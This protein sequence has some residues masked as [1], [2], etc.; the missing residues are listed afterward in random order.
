MLNA[1]SQSVGWKFIMAFGSV[2]DRVLPDGSRRRKLYDSL[3]LR[4]KSRLIRRQAMPESDGQVHNLTQDVEARDSQFA[5]MTTSQSWGMTAR[6]LA[7]KRRMQALG[8]WSRK[9]PSLAKKFWFICRHDG[10]GMAIVRTKATIRNIWKMVH[11][12]EIAHSSLHPS[13][14]SY[15]DVD[16]YTN[17]EMLKP[18]DIVVIDNTYE[19]AERS[20]KFSLIVTVLNE[21]AGIQSFLESIARQSWVPDE[22]VVVDGGSVDRTAEQ[23]ELLSQNYQLNLTLHRS[24]G[25]TIA[26]GRNMAIFHA[27][28]ELVVVTDVG[29]TLEPDFCRSLVGS[30]SDFPEASLVG[31]IYCAAQGAKA[32]DHFIPEWNT[33]DWPQFLP[34]SRSLLIRKS[35]WGGR[36]RLSRIPIQDWRR[37]LVRYL[38]P[39]AFA[40]VG[41]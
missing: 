12:K 19:Q 21:E 36:W 16:P 22:I 24:P 6:I 30:L 20:E 17:V 33:N 28:H 38:V 27:L 3:L 2:K 37:H 18:I 26:A 14:D 9:L 41:V 39:P 13:P 10:W 1:I 7:C 5:Q 8:E 35:L 15:V 23:I 31:G 32:A 11:Q 34:S 40:V 29:C 25:A 4:T